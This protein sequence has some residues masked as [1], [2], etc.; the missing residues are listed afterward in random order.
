[1]SDALRG[2]DANLLLPLQALL[3]ERNLTRAGARMSMTQPS[4]SGALARLRRHFDDELLARTNHGYELTDLA[5]EL[6]PLLADAVASVEE[7]FGVPG[8]FRPERSTRRFTLGVSEYAATVLCGPLIRRLR[9][10]A[11]GCSVVF[12]ELPVM[13]LGHF[14]QQLLR[15][16]LIIGPTWNGMP[17]QRQPVFADRLECIVARDNPRLADGCLSLED[18]G[19]MPLAILTV[20]PPGPGPLEDALD[21]AGISDLAA[22]GVRIN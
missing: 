16:D 22:R 10:R 6:L 4:M 3:E 21:R 2:V 7:L 17:G 14:E 18:L 1:M 19:E 13:D 5:Q 9:E 20:G 12:E 15:Q 8:P 11:P